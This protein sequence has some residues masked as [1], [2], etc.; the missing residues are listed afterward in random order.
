VGDALRTLTAPRLKMNSGCVSSS[1]AESG[2]SSLIV[3]HMGLR[4]VVRMTASLGVV[5]AVL[6][7]TLATA[8]TAPSDSPSSKPPTVHAAAHGAGAVSAAVSTRLTFRLPEV[9]GEVYTPNARN[10]ALRTVAH[11]PLMLFLPATRAVPRDYRLFL[12]AAQSVGYHVLALD[13]WN[14]GQSVAHT[15]GADPHC[16]GDVQAN[17]FDGSHPTRYSAI[18]SSDSILS[19]LTHAL[20]LLA[21]RDPHGGWGAYLTADRVNWNR[22]VLAGHSQ[23]GGESA[24]IAHVHR[25]QGVLLFASP[26]ASDGS[27]VASW[28]TQ[29]GRTPSSRYWGFDSSGDVYF[30]RIQGSWAALKLGGTASA[31]SVTDAVP[32]GGAHRLV[33]HLPLGTPGEAHSR[34]I[35][36]GGPRTASGLPVF[37]PI[38]LWMLK[39]ARGSTLTS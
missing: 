16:Y 8:G 20:Q 9:H 36:D 18:Q 7:G 4:A 24:Y 33:T 38:W 2:R 39:A 37:R 29:A 25:V 19:R 17:R 15:C 31:V 10:I 34:M 11:G 21:E 6:L 26:V 35:S 5:C 13:Y 28:L 12:D 22:V 30:S 1:S 14:L 27:V 3:T 23:G 32:F